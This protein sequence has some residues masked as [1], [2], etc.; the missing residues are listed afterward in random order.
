MI[1]EF[2]HAAYPYV[3]LG[4]L[5]A[6]ACAHL[7]QRNKMNNEGNNHTTDENNA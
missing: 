3:A 7:D 1:Y 6:I 2:L 4:I 5:V